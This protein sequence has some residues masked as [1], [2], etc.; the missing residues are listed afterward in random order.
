MISV[1]QAF[2]VEAVGRYAVALGFIRNGISAFND[3]PDS[4]DLEFR[5][6]SL[7]V[8]RLSPMPKA[9]A[10]DCYGAVGH[11][12]PGTIHACHRV[13]D[14]FADEMCASGRIVNY[15]KAMQVSAKA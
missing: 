4:F 2:F 10:G 11:T 13:I 9:L 8:C 5:H 1:T 7:G 15:L 3:F 12:Q 14:I 6:E